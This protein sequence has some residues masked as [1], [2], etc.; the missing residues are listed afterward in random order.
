MEL[1]LRSKLWAP[2]FEVSSHGVSSGAVRTD[3]GMPRGV[4]S[5]SGSR[6]VSNEQLLYH[7]SLNELIVPQQAHNDNTFLSSILI[8]S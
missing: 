7:A 4:C 5:F 8:T 2:W 1:M 6:G 3:H